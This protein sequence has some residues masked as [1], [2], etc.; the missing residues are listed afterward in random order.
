MRIIETELSGV[1]IIENFHTFDDRGEFTKTYHEL[2]FKNNDLC[3]DFKE[4]FFSISKRDVIRGMH[5]QV[6]PYDHEKLVYVVKGEM[7][8]VVLD[9]RKSSK[10]YKKSI[11]VILS[12]KNHRSI[13]IPK[14]LAHGFKS[15]TDET[16]TVYNVSTIYN[17]ENDYGIRYDSFGFDWKVSD[18]ILSER[19]SDFMTLNNFLNENP[20]KKDKL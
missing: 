6:P 14:G 18:P 7:V 2:V 16:I 5:F 17:K 12:D 3:T 4:S 15:I 8:D 13:Y 10:T 20:F 11:S 9:L 19:D 1:F